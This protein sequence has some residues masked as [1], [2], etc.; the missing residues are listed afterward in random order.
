MKRGRGSAALVII[1]ALALT[2]SATAGG[3][4]AK[5]FKDEGMVIGAS[6]DANLTYTLMQEQCVFPPP[7]QGLDAWVSELPKNFGDGKHYIEVT[8]T[9]MAVDPR[10][11]VD[12][13]FLTS[14]CEPAGTIATPDPNEAGF[15]P[16]GSY[17]VVSLI[18]TTALENV[19]VEAWLP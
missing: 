13:H 9:P 7:T 5:R 3:K 6:A 1:V 11:D 16:P 10:P 17:Y 4:K 14:D 2:S 8:T 12:L 15:I 18:Y 19:T